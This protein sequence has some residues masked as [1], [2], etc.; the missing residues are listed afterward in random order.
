MAQLG[1]GFA[2]GDVVLILDLTVTHH[3]PLFPA[4]GIIRKFLDPEKEQAEKN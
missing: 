3:Q 2:V 4:I 1:E